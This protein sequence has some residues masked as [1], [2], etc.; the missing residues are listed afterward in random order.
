MSFLSNLRRAIPK[1]GRGGTKRGM[2]TPRRAGAP[3]GGT[4]G[5]SSILNTALNWI[6]GRRRRR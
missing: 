5:Q 2:G 6:G 1:A 3:A 4:R